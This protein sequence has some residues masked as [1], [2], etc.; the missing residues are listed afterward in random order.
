EGALRIANHQA[1]TVSPSRSVWGTLFVALTIGFGCAS[2][3]NVD[4]E[5]DA[6]ILGDAPHVVPDAPIPESD[7][8]DPDV[9][10]RGGSDGRVC[11]VGSLCYDPPIC[12]RGTCTPRQ[13]SDGTVCAPT[14]AACKQAGTCQA[15][16][17]GPV[18]N[19]SDGTVCPPAS[20]ACHTDGVCQA[21]TC[22]AQG[23]RPNG[24]N[25]QAGAIYRCCGGVPSQINTSQHCGVC[26][27]SC[28]GQS[29]INVGGA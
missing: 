12:V 17:C 4:P 19:A 3:E 24:Y 5:P 14:S 13:Q 16:V 22:G 25:Y 26:G 23:V 21:G 6:L 18:T 10:S 9:C 11:G 7:A 8:A 29:C 28:G 20:N 27:I 15:G 2:G 1:H